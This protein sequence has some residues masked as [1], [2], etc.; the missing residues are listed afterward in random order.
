MSCS[1]LARCAI[2]YGHGCDVG[3]NG[4]RNKSK[5]PPA[6]RALESLVNGA[7]L[8]SVLGKHLPQP[9]GLPSQHA[10]DGGQ[11]QADS[12]EQARHAEELERR[13]PELDAVD[14]RQV[15]QDTTTGQRRVELRRDRV[16]PLAIRK[17][18]R[19]NCYDQRY[20]HQHHA[21]HHQHRERLGG[22]GGLYDPHF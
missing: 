1:S 4:L 17:R 14:G 11:G 22:H 19:R 20:H 2:V 10:D 8:R 12:G 6:R 15:V 16:V 13:Q 21:H 18:C 3:L 5:G 7:A 9:T